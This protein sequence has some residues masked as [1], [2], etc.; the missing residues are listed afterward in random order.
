VDWLA[1]IGIGLDKETLRLERATDEWVIAGARVRD[2][3]AHLLGSTVAAVAQIGSS[4]VAGLL[5][6]PIIDLAVGITPMHELEVVRRTLVENGWQYRG[7]SG[8]SGGHVFV[9]ELRPGHRVAHLHVVDH[10]GTQWRNYLTLRDTLR[11]DPAARARYEA[12]KLSLQAE[13]GH[14]REAY[15]EGKTTVIRSLLTDQ[16]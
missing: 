5:A 11:R 13:F 10:E 6:K 3:V 8:D 12:E 15:T 14:D 9:F 4:S 2:E 7:D 1:D 16:P